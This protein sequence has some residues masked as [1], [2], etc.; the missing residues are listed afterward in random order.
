MR[1]VGVFLWLE[2]LA[3]LFYCFP[4]APCSQPLSPFFSL[5][6]VFV[7]FFSPLYWRKLGI[8][9]PLG[10]FFQ[11]KQQQNEISLT[12]LNFDCMSKELT[13]N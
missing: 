13:L 8:I 12:V 5:I 1:V 2:I 10:S 11:D 7:F 9:C 3:L 4:P 6:I